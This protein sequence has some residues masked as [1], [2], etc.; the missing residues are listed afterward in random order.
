MTLPASS[1]S[2]HSPADVAKSSGELCVEPVGAAHAERLAA[3]FERNRAAGVAETFDPFPLTAEQARR[4]AVEPRQ[5]AYFLATL[6]GREVGLSMLRGFDE[7]YEMPS[8]GVFIDHES[9][10]RGLGRALTAWTLAAARER[11]CGAVRLSV[12]ADNPAALA[13]YASLGFVER[14]RE[15]VT[16]AG[17]RVEKL[18]LRL[19]F[20]A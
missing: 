1:Q 7:G 2:R 19:D 8:F 13:I 6:D 4:I 14:E 12:Y 3:L 18:V 20:G 11:G 16:R 9:Q 10:G 17:S 5:D 15:A